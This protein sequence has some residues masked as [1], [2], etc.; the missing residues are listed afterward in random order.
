MKN[1]LTG[2]LN[3]FYIRGISRTINTKSS[4]DLC[5]RK[6]PQDSFRDFSIQFSWIFPGICTRI[7]SGTVQA[8]V[9]RMRQKFSSNSTINSS[10]I[11]LVTS[12]WVS[13]VPWNFLRNSFNEI[14]KGV[15]KNFITNSLQDCFS[16]SSSFFQKCFHL[17]KFE[18]LPQW[19]IMVHELL[20]INSS[21]DV[22][23]EIYHEKNLPKCLLVFWQ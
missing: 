21:K 20:H 17:W 2:I 14:F 1:F 16:D 23:L 5:G 10:W 7:S 15:S 4:I 9:R 6:F 8:L 19:T 3:A 13:P 22:F 18:K 12:P 11:S